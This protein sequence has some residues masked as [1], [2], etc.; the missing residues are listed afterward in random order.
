MTVPPTTP[1]TTE[2]AF[3]LVPIKKILVNNN[4]N[5]NSNICNRRKHRNRITAGNG[6]RSNVNAHDEDDN[7]FVSLESPTVPTTDDRS[8]DEIEE[9]L[10][11]SKKKNHNDRETHG[12]S[13]RNNNN[14]KPPNNRKPISRADCS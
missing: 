13:S 10:A 2:I 1:Q 5:I 9:A 12:A 3:V 6:S 4:S 8:L 14:N 11:R 7:P